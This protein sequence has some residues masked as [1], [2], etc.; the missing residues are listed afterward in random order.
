[1]PNPTAHAAD[2][3]S[4]AVIEPNNTPAFWW[5][6]PW[7]YALNLKRALHAVHALAITT[8]DELRE[9]H[10]DRS[11]LQQT[12]HE[13]HALLGNAKADHNAF[14]RQVELTLKPACP[15]LYE[16][17]I[18]YVHWAAD[19]IKSL[20]TELAG[21]TE[22][23]DAYIE[24]L[25]KTKAE[26]DSALKRGSELQERCRLIHGNHEPRIHGGEAPDLD[27]FRFGHMHVHEKPKIKRKPKRVVLAEDK[28]TGKKLLAPKKKA[29]YGD[30][31][32]DYSAIGR[33]Y[34]KHL[35]LVQARR[36]AIAKAKKKGGR[37]G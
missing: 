6:N 27:I 4:L 28:T 12:K 37:R 14:Q 24:K 1:M 3:K 2:M 29:K 18:S 7:G 10:I 32:D 20:R 22:D 34:L 9:A 11:K 23:R 16:D 21:I 13:L 30:G 17:T 35:A 25:D 8:G 33:R 36:K 15:H 31:R 5:V 26:L 19:E